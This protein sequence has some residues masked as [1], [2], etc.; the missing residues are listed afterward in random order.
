MPLTIGETF[1]GYTI[2]RLLGSG[3]MGEVYL[4]QHPRLPRQ[5]RAASSAT[6]TPQR[7]QSVHIPRLYTLLAYLRVQVQ[8]PRW[9][10]LVAVA[11]TLRRSLIGRSTSVV[12]WVTG[13]KMHWRSLGNSLIGTRSVWPRQRKRL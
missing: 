2:L 10:R 7:L 3:G 9:L 5:P 1:A 8:P 6:T 13:P 4:A 12:T 11:I